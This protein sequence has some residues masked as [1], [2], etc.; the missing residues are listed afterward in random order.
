M[1]ELFSS[2]KW[3]AEEGDNVLCVDLQTRQTNEQ[4]ATTCIE[5]VTIHAMFIWISAAGSIEFA[6]DDELRKGRVTARKA[7]KPALT[8]RTVYHEAMPAD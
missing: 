7:K 2:P 5:N 1:N 6:D 4:G 8:T 3:M